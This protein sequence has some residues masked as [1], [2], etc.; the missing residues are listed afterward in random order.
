MPGQVNWIAVLA[1][2]VST[3]LIGGLWYSPL[4]FGRAWMGENGLTDA[5]LRTGTGKIF[6]LSFVF[7]LAMAANLAMF[8]ADGKTTTA[9]GLPVSSPALVG[10]RSGSR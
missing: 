9:W 7:S 8:L 3:F 10:W 6:G 4:L 1:A 2:A 5:A